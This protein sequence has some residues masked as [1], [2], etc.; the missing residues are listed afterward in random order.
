MTL[1]YPPEVVAGAVVVLAA[2]RGLV[3]RTLTRLA[4]WNAVRPPAGVSVEDWQSAIA[5]TG[6]GAASWLGALESLLAYL[7]FVAFQENAASIIGGWLAFK[8]ASKWESWQ[9]VVRVPDS[10]DGVGNQLDFLRARRQWG[11]VLYTRFLI[12]T[13]LNVFM[14]VIGGALVSLLKR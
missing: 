12:G 9:N 6:A 14:G 2:S 1:S 4:P 8:V 5:G 11:S 3:G 13:L 7:A 10:L